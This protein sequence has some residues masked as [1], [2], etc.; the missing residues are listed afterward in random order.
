MRM[1]FFAAVIIATVSRA[2]VGADITI[3]DVRI[4]EGDSGD[5]LAE[6]TVS[7]SPAAIGP[8]TVT[9]NTKDGT[10]MAG[11]DYRTANG[12][13]TFARGEV[14]KKIAIAVVGDTATEPDETFQVVLSNAS[15]ATITRAIAAVTIVN[16][17]AVGRMPTY[18]VRFT[19][20]G[21]TGAMASAQDCPVRR[22]GK[23][24]MTGLVSGSENVAATDDIEYTGT[25]QLEADI[26]LCETTGLDDQA[27]LCS[28]RVIGGGPVRVELSVY[29]DNRGGYIKSSK[30]PGNW[31]SNI[32]GSCDAQQIN[33][34]RSAFPDNSYANSFQGDEF[35]L[36][37]GPLK[38]GKYARGELLV[39]VL[40]VVR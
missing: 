21:F 16:D 39:E 14:A 31:W 9:Y 17:D 10:A 7:L 25:L 27:R 19:Y 23:V 11:P 32:F 18:E 38:K 34:E 40:R 12:T 24:A 35:P 2:A 37:S 3:S 29:A 22:N 20:T 5:R 26:D 6:V 28:I 33:E 13:V 1:W 30:A 15:G 36:P 8:V 4:V